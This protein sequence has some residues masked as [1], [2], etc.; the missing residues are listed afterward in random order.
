MKL[1][2]LVEDIRKKKELN[3]LSYDFIL[4]LLKEYIKINSHLNKNI[5]WIS[6]PKSKNYKKTIKDLRKILR[7]VY[8]V[9]KDKDFLTK[10]I[11]LED[12]SGLK[13]IDAHIELLK[14][15]ASTKE[16][17]P[18]Y[19]EVYGKIVGLV[20]KMDTILDLGAGFNPL[21]MP[22]MDFKI[23]NYCAVE[24]TENDVIF[25]NKY[26]KKVH[27]RG[28][29][30]VK[31]LTKVGDLPQVDVCFIFKLLD[32]L[33]T[34]KKDVSEE[35]L[36]GLN[37]RWVII[38]FATKSLGGKKNISKN[39]LKWFKEIIK[40]YEYKEFEIPNEIFFVIKLK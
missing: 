7:E 8:G 25:L 32:T 30:I 18:Y 13:D 21:S 14:L 33:E 37:A 16:R 6:N 2:K 28:H 20:D 26:F 38:S 9:F 22:F 39:R 31:D 23:K 15:H 12:I 40:N 27:V 5:G 36:K 19:F 34:L 35:I 10:E 24:L 29:A 3:D 17:L 11:L 4:G 1:R